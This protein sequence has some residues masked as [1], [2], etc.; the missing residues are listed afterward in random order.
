[1]YTGNDKDLRNELDYLHRKIE[2]L[3]VVINQLTLHAREKRDETVVIEEIKQGSIAIGKVKWIHYVKE[4]EYK[5][6]LFEQF[7]ITLEDD[8]KYYVDKNKG[9]QPQIEDGDTISYKIDG[10]K[11]RSVRVLYDV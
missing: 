3:V 1:M 5:G 4:Y 10:D 7:L 6:K 8:S 11:L 2:E 9:A